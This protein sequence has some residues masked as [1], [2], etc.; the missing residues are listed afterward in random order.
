MSIFR[1]I[2]F[3]LVMTVILRCDIDKFTGYNYKGETP[4][5]TAIIAGNVKN[6]FTNTPVSFATLKFGEYITHA[7]GSGN[8]SLVY[9]LGTDDERDKPIPLV[10]SRPNYFQIETEIIVYPSQNVHN[11]ALVYAAPIIESSQLD[12][13]SSTMVVCYATILDYQGVD[14]IDSVEGVFRYESEGVL[15]LVPVQ[16]NEDV[17]LSENRAQFKCNLDVVASEG[18]LNPKS[19]KITVIDKSGFS[20]SQDFI[21]PF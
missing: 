14:D 4:I 9:P 16:L 5:E 18:N 19:Y 10:V 13:I 12:F 17:R 1:L 15:T 21:R 2:I 7:D 11:F 3:V 20:D 6:I 8:Y